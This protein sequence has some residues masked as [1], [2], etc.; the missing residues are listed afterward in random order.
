MNR[1]SDVLDHWGIDEHE[2]ERVVRGLKV[3]RA[4]FALFALLGLAV[5]F[6]S[7]SLIV[8]YE[9][10]LLILLGVFVVVCRTWRIGVLEKRRFVF[11]SQWLLGDKGE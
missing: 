10:W 8:F 2:L 4:I 9:G 3:E 5:A 1:F 7:K 6:N 11:F